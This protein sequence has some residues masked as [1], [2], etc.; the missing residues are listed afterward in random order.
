MPI[1]WMD[2]VLESSPP[3]GALTQTKRTFIED[4]QR[5]RLPEARRKQAMMALLQI[6]RKGASNMAKLNGLEL[7]IQKAKKLQ[8]KQSELKPFEDMLH[9][10]RLAHAAK[11]LEGQLKMKVKRAT[12]ADGIEPLRNAIESAKKYKVDKVDGV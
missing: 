6:K 8:I 2:L 4:I 7:T 12:A 11:A 5:D 3:F 9:E 1:E 10:A